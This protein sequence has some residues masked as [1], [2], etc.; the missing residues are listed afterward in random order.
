MNIYEFFLIFSFY[1][2]LSELTEGS[3][4]YFSDW[5]TMTCRHEPLMYWA[6]CVVMVMT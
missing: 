3:V 2:G 6:M 4:F 1:S 5:Q